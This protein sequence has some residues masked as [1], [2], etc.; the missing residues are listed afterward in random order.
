MVNLLISDPI[1]REQLNNFIFNALRPVIATI[2]PWNG[3][4]G[5]RNEN[6]E[7]SVLVTSD[8]EGIHFTQ[9]AWHLPTTSVI[10]DELQED[11]SALQP[12][13]DS[14]QNAMELAIVP[15]IPLGPMSPIAATTQLSEESLVPSLTQLNTATST[16]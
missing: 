6:M 15:V 12:I 3:G 2:G 13:D 14:C 8:A 16:E 9:Q 5:L 10:T 4:Y 7:V 1:P 11:N